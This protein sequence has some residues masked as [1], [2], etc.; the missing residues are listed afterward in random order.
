MSWRADAPWRPDGRDEPE[1]WGLEAIWRD[2]ERPMAERIE[3][4]E[5][6]RP[7]EVAEIRE[8]GAA[9]GAA[10]GR[11][12]SAA[13]V[14]ARAQAILALPLGTFRERVDLVCQ[15]DLTVDDARQVLK[16]R[17]ARRGDPEKAA[18]LA[19]L[20]ADEEAL[21]G[22]RA[23]HAPSRDDPGADQ[24]PRLRRAMRRRSPRPRDST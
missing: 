16:L 9:E 21:A 5:A 15:W 4:L 8:A 14:R 17:A 22:L 18:I 2:P 10:G 6:D 11:S 1:P 3:A 13:E 19:G 7:L 12:E 20:K 24:V 23:A